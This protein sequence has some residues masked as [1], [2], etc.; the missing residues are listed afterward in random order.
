MNQS[1]DVP[2]ANIPEGRAKGNPELARFFSERAKRL[3]VVATTRTPSGQVIDW[4]P[5]G[6]QA[7]EGQIATPPPRSPAT[8]P[9]LSEGKAR[10][11][12]R[13]PEGVP[14]ETTA[15]VEV[16][17]QEVEPGPEGT[18]PVVRQDSSHI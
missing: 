17:S 4:V 14:S 9:D 3:K 15:E 18:V 2:A 1:S 7:P 8:P 11:P 13:L 6:S 12:G 10:R 16:Q 5:V